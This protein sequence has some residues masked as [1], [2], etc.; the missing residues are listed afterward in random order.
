MRTSRITRL[1]ASALLAA[2]SITSTAAFAEIQGL[3]DIMSIEAAQTHLELAAANDLYTL[4]Q[5]T[6]KFLVTIPKGTV[7]NVD[8]QSNPEN[9]D[10]VDSAGQPHRSSTGFYQIKLVEVAGQTTPPRNLEELN[11]LA[12]HLYLS[13]SAVNEAMSQ[14]AIMPLPT[15]VPQSEYLKLYEESGHPKF[16]FTARF[17]ARF[18]TQLNRVVRPDEQSV[19]EKAKWA[20][21]MQELVSV[22]D[23]KH[24]SPGQLLYISQSLA[25]KYS[26]DFE[27]TGVIQPF[28]AWSIAVTGTA[29]RHGFENVP[30][31]EFMSEVLRQAYTRA[32]YDV[33]EDFNASKDNRLYWTS[34]AAVVN[35]ATAMFKGSW[36]PWEAVKFK[37]QTGA[38]AMNYLADSPGHA[39]MYAGENGQLVV[40]NGSP[41]GRDLRSTSFKIINMMYQH[42]V[43]FLPPGVIPQAW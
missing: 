25:T 33:K 3:T 36:I 30:C 26:E 4:N 8:P 5:S 27:N 41:R 13:T 37:P 18:G 43:F 39:Y 2:L 23:R 38:I 35:L 29:R 6:L 12:G 7:I 28:G 17:Q 32:G 24:Q 9:Y 10:Y 40:D 19:Q 34:T 1:G 42:G 22:G 16:S 31:A 21:I 20:A 11:A 14:G 15:T